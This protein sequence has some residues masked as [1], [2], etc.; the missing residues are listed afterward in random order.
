MAVRADHVAAERSFF[1]RAN[2]EYGGAGSF[3][4]G[5]RL[6]LNANASQTLET[7]LEQQ[8]LGCRINGGALPGAP[9]KR[10]PDLDPPVFCGD[11]AEAGRTGDLARG[12]VYDH[13]RKRRTG[14]CMSDT[15]SYEALDSYSGLQWLRE[16]ACDAGADS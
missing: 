1:E 15:L 8:H 6:Q 11:R 5:I 10:P 2:S 16:P 7:M 12:A 13:E 14:R 3:V 4:S 9:D